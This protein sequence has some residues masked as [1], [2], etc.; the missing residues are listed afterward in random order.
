V[1]RNRPRHQF[2]ELALELQPD[3][4]EER[5]RRALEAEPEADEE[6]AGHIPL[7]AGSPPRLREI[8]RPRGDDG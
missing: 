2:D 5:Q 7:S 8:G 1:P 6:A 4:V 3:R